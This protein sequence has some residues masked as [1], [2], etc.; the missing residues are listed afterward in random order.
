MFD[1]RIL[2]FGLVGLVGVAVNLA[3]VRLL[4]GQLHWAA[5]FASAVAVEL[6]IVGNFLGNNWWT[7]GERTL[8]IVRFFRYNL[9]ALGGLAITAGTFT[10]LMQ[11]TGVPYLIAD[12]VGIALATG[13]NFAVSVLWTWSR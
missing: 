4:F 7:F 13:W 9:A 8:S 6:S 3:V 11:H 10:L 2:R 12:L 5:P 1:V